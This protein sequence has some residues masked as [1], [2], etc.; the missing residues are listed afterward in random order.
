MRMDV[1]SE[2]EILQIENS[3]TPNQ[4]T[5]YKLGSYSRPNSGIQVD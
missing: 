2:P 3:F 4:E 5:F 1:E